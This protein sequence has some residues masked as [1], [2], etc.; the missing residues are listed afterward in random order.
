MTEMNIKNI[1]IIK[2]YWILITVHKNMTKITLQN[3]KSINNG[4]KIKNKFKKKNNNSNKKLMWPSEIKK[5]YLV[6]VLNNKNKYM[7]ISTKKERL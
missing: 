4:I 1:I 7:K 5:V 2:K 3:L 6:I